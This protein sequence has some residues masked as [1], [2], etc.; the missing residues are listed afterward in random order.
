MAA[1]KSLSLRIKAEAPKNSKNRKVCT[2]FGVIAGLFL[3]YLLYSLEVEG[4]ID[5]EGRIIR[6]SDSVV[7]EQ[8]QDAEFS[9]DV[10]LDYRE[11]GNDDRVC[12]L[13]GAVCFNPDQA[14][15]LQAPQ[16]G[17]SLDD[18]LDNVEAGE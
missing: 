6:D 5:D 16:V 7:I 2:S 15:G 17:I 9:G 12:V 4:M 18:P 3:G 14:Q 13:L 10:G 11:L 8:I 1:N